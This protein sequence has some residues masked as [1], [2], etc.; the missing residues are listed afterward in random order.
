M[1]H[2]PEQNIC[3]F[4]KLKNFRDHFTS[5]PSK[6]LTGE[7]FGKYD[8]CQVNSKIKPN[9]HKLSIE[10]TNYTRH[11]KFAALN[12]VLNMALEP[13]NCIWR[14]SVGYYNYADEF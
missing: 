4:S 5:L 1:P 8:I 7:F 6:K 14:A 2:L 9:C 13:P 3:D 11:R 10:L 12:K